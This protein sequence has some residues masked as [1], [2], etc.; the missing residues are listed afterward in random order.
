MLK[1][2][3]WQIFAKV[4]QQAES[5]YKTPTSSTVVST[6]VQNKYIY[7]HT[8]KKM[9]AQ[10]RLAF[11]EANV[12]SILSLWSRPFSTHFQ[13][14]KEKKK[15][16]VG[17]VEQPHKNDWYATANKT[18]TEIHTNYYSKKQNIKHIGKWVLKKK[19]FFLQDHFF[20]C[21]QMW[22]KYL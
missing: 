12:E 6:T 1:P 5:S 20:G 7:I 10:T 4:K 18:Q 22:Y 16:R 8:Q 3:I 17:W 15:R 21:H 11:F 2:W 9:P 13:N 14:V 19:K